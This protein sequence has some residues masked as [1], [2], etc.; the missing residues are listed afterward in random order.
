[1]TASGSTHRGNSGP[2]AAGSAA[3]CT[4][5]PRAGTGG[6]SAAGGV[7][8]GGD[9]RRA[10]GSGAGSGGRGSGRARR[11]PGVHGRH[12]RP[13]S[14]PVRRRHRGER[15]VVRPRLRCRLPRRRIPRG[16]R[17][18]GVVD[19]LPP[20]ADARAVPAA[21]AL[22][23]AARPSETARMPDPSAPRS[24]GTPRPGTADAYPAPRAP[25]SRPA[26]HRTPEAPAGPAPATRTGRARA[27]A[28]VVSTTLASADTFAARVTPLP[29]RRGHRTAPASG[30]PHLAGHPHPPA[31]DPGGPGSR[32]APAAV[33]QQPPRRLT[34][35]TGKRRTERAG[36]RAGGQGGE[37]EQGPRCCRESRAGKQR[38]HR[39]RPAWRPPGKYPGRPRPD[40]PGTSSAHVTAARQERQAST[41]AEARTPIPHAGPAQKMPRTY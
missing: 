41:P 14:A 26:R 23:E 10:A 38:A 17:G 6:G 7:A 12:G 3:R 30:P 1:M 16:L 22:P 11:A 33:R 32:P 25:R 27:P 28:A 40:R 19:P 31:D 24:P 20:A 34:R 21:S 13:H 9:R 37:K 4:G 39:R 18:R 5:C 2:N 29:D 8:G 36:N 15:A 35:R